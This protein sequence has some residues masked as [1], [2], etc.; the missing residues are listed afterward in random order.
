M[1]QTKKFPLG[2]NIVVDFERRRAAAPVPGQEA[3]AGES[4]KPVRRRYDD[5]YAPRRAAPVTGIYLFDL[6]TRLRSV[7]ES[8]FD[9]LRLRL[10]SEHDAP[11]RVDGNHDEYV[12]IDTNPSNAAT[13]SN[14]AARDAQN[15]ALL[16]SRSAGSTDAMDPLA[17]YLANGSGRK[18]SAC[19][20]IPYNAHTLRLS[21]NI[22]AGDKRLTEDLAFPNRLTSW[23]RRTAKPSD[24]AEAWNDLNVDDDVP[25]GQGYIN[26]APSNIQVRPID[27]PGVDFYVSLDVNAANIRITSEPSYDG[28]VL[29]GFA[30]NKLEKV[31]LRPCPLIWQLRFFTWY[32][33]ISNF[34]YSGGPVTALPVHR[35]QDVLVNFIGRMPVYPARPL[36][37][38]KP[39][40]ATVASRQYARVLSQMIERTPGLQAK[41]D[42]ADAAAT[43]PS[44][45]ST[46]S[47]VRDGHTWTRVSGA[48][49]TVTKLGARSMARLQL[50]NASVRAG[51]LLGIISAGGFEYYIW[52][53]TNGLITN[54]TADLLEVTWPANAPT[55][56]VPVSVE[57]FGLPPTAIY[58]AAEDGY[59]PVLNAHD[60]STG[61]LTTN[62]ALPVDGLKSVSEYQT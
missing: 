22:G 26:D 25:F 47:F 56:G 36:R 40:S 14:D 29:G 39:T 23:T 16:G 37:T 2:S 62:V 15:A 1:S 59:A 45:S 6:G 49:A 19:M 55:D 9:G 4:S 38:T 43:T 41:I 7:N 57:D 42:A 46:A 17:E 54:G 30:P 61:A 50:V 58:D 48:G 33:F 35:K 28:F 51:T 3:A 11:V 18:L 12:E 52:K 5:E 10:A 34:Q 24:A 13:L 44:L 31:W 20:P 60:A 53:T 27:I 8:S 21:A 32:E